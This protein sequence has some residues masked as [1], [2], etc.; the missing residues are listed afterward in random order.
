[1]INWSK[2]LHTLAH[3]LGLDYE[4]ALFD[5]TGKKSSK[6]LTNKEASDL[7]ATWQRAINDMETKYGW[8]KDKY[9][10]LA[11]RPAHLATPGQL[12]LIE[13]LW[14]QVTRSQSV[15][16]R[17]KTLNDLLYNKHEC[18]D[19]IQLP[20]AKV[21]KVIKTLESMGAEVHR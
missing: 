14:N 20:K 1:M 21:E 7:C 19:I 3:K 11:P 6:A 10:C 12:R 2:R 9:N 18:A 4:Q 13:S 15:P 17:E 5:A 8:G 16:G